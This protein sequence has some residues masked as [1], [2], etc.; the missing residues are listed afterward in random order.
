M[1]DKIQDI[2]DA[3]EELEDVAE[4]EIR[5]KERY[6]I[7]LNVLEELGCSSVEEAEK[8]IMAI[9]TKIAKKV[10]KFTEEFN[11]F[12]EDYSEVLK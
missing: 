2:K 4:E 6:A 8:E 5:A 1:Q 10:K 7:T 11:D 9:D 3:I 12:I